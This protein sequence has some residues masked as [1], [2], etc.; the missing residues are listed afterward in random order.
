[1]VILNIITFFTHLN[2]ALG[3]SAQLIMQWY[4]ITESPR[5]SIDHSEFGCGIFIDKKRHLIQLIILFFYQNWIMMERDVKP[6]TGFNRICPIEN[7]ICM[8]QWS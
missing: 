7:V 5:N 1:M 2:L 3:K 4:K 6:M 8:Y